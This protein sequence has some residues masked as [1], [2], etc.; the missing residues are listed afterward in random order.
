M[1][2]GKTHLVCSLAV[3]LTPILILA[4]GAPHDT[5]TTPCLSGEPGGWCCRGALTLLGVVAGLFPD[6]DAPESELLHVARNLSDRTGWAAVAALGLRRTGLPG[7][8]IG[9]LLGMPG[10]LVSGALAAVSILLRSVS[11]HRGL[12][13]EL[14]G[15]GLCTGL[16]MLAAAGATGLCRLPP[17]LGLQVTLLVGAF[18]TLGYLTH[19]LLDAA[20]IAGIPLLSARR[21]FHLLPRAWRVRT[22]SW[23]DTVL[24][25]GVAGAWLIL[26]LLARVS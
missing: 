17:S 5:I 10:A 14:R 18:W 12:T 20:T 9:A 15:V 25:R 3:V 8:M 26:L 11:H 6:L 16:V 4:P 7:R 21:T 23:P 13:H 1:C 19:L 2:T 22:G 24:V